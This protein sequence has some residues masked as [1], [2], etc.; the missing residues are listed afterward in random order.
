MRNFSPLTDLQTNLGGSWMQRESFIDL[1]G[2]D[3]RRKQDM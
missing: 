1:L 3:M 2:A